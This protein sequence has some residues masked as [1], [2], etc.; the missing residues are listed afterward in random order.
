MSAEEDTPAPTSPP[1]PTSIPPGPAPPVI[2]RSEGLRPSRVFIGNRAY[3]DFYNRFVE[4][5]FTYSNSYT[6]SHLRDSII[7][8]NGQVYYRSEEGTIT[9]H[10]TPGTF[11]SWQEKERF[12]DALSKCSIHR[13]DL[14]QERVKTKSIL[15]IM[16]YYTHL[17][18]STEALKNR[19]STVVNRFGLK[20]NWS[21]KLLTYHE[22]PIAYE[23]SPYFINFEELQTESIGYRE[24]TFELA[25]ATKLKSSFAIYEDLSLINLDNFK[26]LFS[27]NLGFPALILI[28]EL[29]RLLTKRIILKVISTHSNSIR[30]F[31]IDQAIASLNYNDPDSLFNYRNMWI[32][33]SNL[34]KEK[35]NLYEP[36]LYLDPTFTIPQKHQG[37]NPKGIMHINSLRK[38]NIANISEELDEELEDMLIEHETEELEALD[39]MNSKVHERGLATML[40]PSAYYEPEKAQDLA[41]LWLTEQR[42]LE[43]ESESE[44]ES[45]EEDVDNTSELNQQVAPEQ[46]QSNVAE[47]DTQI[48]LELIDP[49]LTNRTPSVAPEDVPIEVQYTCQEPSTQE[50]PPAELPNQEPAAEEPPT[51]KRKIS[52]S[53]IHR[54]VVDS[55][56]YTYANYDKN[57]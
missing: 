55:Y 47:A 31:D 17:K 38:G 50:P 40:L 34:Q 16:N 46:I 43:N 36:T 7:A 4:E 52:P 8:H 9:E 18:K 1:A 41:A 19:K 11:W 33:V 3:V 37:E 39:Q 29:I 56:T 30:K 22:M 48:S 42:E 24:R 2:S 49:E 25:K 13:A 44:S 51:K 23:I 35:R 10:E 53:T 57:S 28:E 14:I 21:T 20:R 12:F 32:E 26:K 45:E 15:E 6:T 5:T 54:L 27:L